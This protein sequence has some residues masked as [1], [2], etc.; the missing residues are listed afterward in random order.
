M[1]LDSLIQID[2][3]SFDNGKE[4]SLFKLL[5]IADEL[6]DEVRLFEKLV[7]KQL[8]ASFIADKNLFY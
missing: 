5:F 3:S 2:I 4:R 6:T 8:L 7:L 1:K